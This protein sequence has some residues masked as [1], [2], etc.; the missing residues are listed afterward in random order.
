MVFH[1]RDILV[2]EQEGEVE[3]PSA[4]LDRDRSDMVGHIELELNNRKAEVH[5]PQKLRSKTLNTENN[6]FL[7][8]GKYL[9]IDKKVKKTDLSRRL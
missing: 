5:K 2:E 8:L 1:I 6:C 9:C 7:L 3:V 4:D